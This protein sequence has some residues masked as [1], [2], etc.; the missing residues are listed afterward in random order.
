MRL[1]WISIVVYTYFIP[2]P[3][4]HTHTHTHTHAHTHGLL[5][6]LTSPQFPTLQAKEQGNSLHLSTL[7][8]MALA[9]HWSSDTTMSVAFT[10][11]TLLA[12]VPPPQL[13]LH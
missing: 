10:Q 9:A 4:T 11:T 13:A 6:T 5:C 1:D 2:V 3:H 8:G 12:R 7:A